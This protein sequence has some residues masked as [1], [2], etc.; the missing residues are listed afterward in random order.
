VKI[1]VII[2]AY[3]RKTFL[4]CAIDS[5]LNQS[6]D[7]NNFEII[8]IKNFPDEQIDSLCV[9]KG[10]YSTLTTNV[11]IGEYI[12]LALKNSSGEIVCFLDDDD[13]FESNKLEMIY[14]EFSRNQDLMF[15][16]N[17]WSLIDSEGRPIKGKSKATLSHKEPIQYFDINYAIKK[18]GIAFRWNMSCISVRREIFDGFESYLPSIIAAQDLI[19]FYLAASK[20]KIIARCNLSLTRYRVHENSMT[21]VKGSNNDALREYNSLKPL[22]AHLPEGIVREDLEKTTAKMRSIS[23]W[24]GSEFT[25]K[26]LRSL[27]NSYLRNKFYNVYDLLVLTFI[28]LVV[29]LASTVGSKGIRFLRKGIDIFW[30][31]DEN[32]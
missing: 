21:K 30:S 8:L 18:I 2:M 27:L 12:S 10:I 31:Y 15:I 14:N 17:N 16:R 32:Y 13:A 1:S 28:S 20:Y 22:I 19:V 26:E 11:P 24:E 29:T 23:I 7:R 25:R 5:V 4:R 9:E 6:L 3:N